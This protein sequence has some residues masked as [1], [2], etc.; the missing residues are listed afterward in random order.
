MTIALH[1]EETERAL[2]LLTRGEPDAIVEIRLLGRK[3]KTDIMS[4][5]FDP[6]AFST[7]ARLLETLLRNS[8][9]NCY[10]TMNS[11]HPGLISRYYRRFEKYPSN[12]TTDSE[13]L[14]YRWIMMD[15]DPVRPSGINA[16]DDEKE[17]AIELSGQVKT[18]CVNNLKLKAPLECASGNGVHLLFPFDMPVNAENIAFVKTLLNTLAQ[19]FNND[20]CKL[21]TA[22]FNPARITKLYGTLSGKGDDIAERPHRFSKITHIPQALLEANHE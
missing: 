2:H 18:F 22:N 20:R 10:V 12:T 15:F 4:G 19:K 7:A 11:L 13:V 14:K 21:D 1:K 6:P 3:K 16:T 9:Y 8:N 17:S 5:Y